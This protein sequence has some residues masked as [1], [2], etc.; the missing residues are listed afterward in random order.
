MEKHEITIPQDAIWVIEQLNN[1]GY[2]AYLVGGCVRD[3]LL[4]K[5]PCDWDI[6]TSAK[7]MEVKRI[8]PKTIDTGLQHGTVTVLRHGVGYEV[9]TYR[10]DGEYEDGRH[11]REVSFTN[12][13][14]ED[15]MRRDF[16]INAMAYHPAH[17]LVD[18]FDG[19]GDLQRGILRCVGNPKDRFTEDALRM[20]RGIRFAAQLNYEIEEE[21]LQAIVNMAAG[22]QKVSAER[23]QVELIK[24]LMSDHPEKFVLFY[25]TGITRY[26]LPQF[27]TAME[28]EQKNPHHYLTVG[29]H[30]LKS[31]E[32]VPADRYLRLTM[33]LHDI[34][35]PK[36]KT[37]GE[38][39]RDHFRGH[40]EQGAKMV[41]RILQDLKFDNHTIQMVT[42]YV[43]YHDYK[44]EPDRAGMRRAIHKVG[45]EFF[46]GLFAV[47]Y[48]DV[49]AQSE[50]LRAS[51]LERLDQLRD[52]YE[53]VL[54]EQECV[55][56]KQLAVT[57][58]DL[59][60]EGIAPGKEIGTLLNT[61][62]EDVL[63]YPEH[64]TKDYLL[65][66]FCGR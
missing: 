46:P 12:S 52:L 32:F 11:P 14:V 58:K 39:L 59:L 44:I 18:E 49:M 45:E 65:K 53:E 28:T 50:E 43:K 40:P 63:Q 13:L 34:A 29:K 8:F 30:M 60:A 66:T 42:G 10:I 25:E 51:K 1:A 38:D 20:M 47:K 4:H 21:T 31:L 6:T 5:Q 3:F 61:M 24:L 35:K 62:L 36:C 15:L 27:D 57:G 23:I 56:L 22:I 7:P 55:S 19:Y 9:T 33:L 48:A 37:T 16:T 54:R 64:N 26:I 17:G 41:K 2:E